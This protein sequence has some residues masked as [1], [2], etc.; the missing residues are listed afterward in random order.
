MDHDKG[1]WEHEVKRDKA[2]DKIAELEAENERLNQRIN[3]SL[4]KDCLVKGGL[5]YGTLFNGDDYVVR[6][7]GYAIV[8]KEDYKALEA[9]RDRLR[10][11]EARNKQLTASNQ[12]LTME[13][14]ALQRELRIARNKLEQ[15]GGT[16]EPQAEA[17]SRPE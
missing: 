2:L 12:G 3:N 10:E 9:E 11:L 8:P 1:D 17:P 6:L 14:N 16:N 15:R 5:Q 7:V 4:I 13:R